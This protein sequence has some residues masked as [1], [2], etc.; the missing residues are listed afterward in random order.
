MHDCAYDIKYHHKLQGFIYNLLKATPYSVLHNKKGYKFISFSNIFPPNDMKKGDTKQLII[1][2]PDKV[3]INVI[4]EKLEQVKEKVCI[5]EMMFEIEGASMLEPKIERSC[6][7]I[8]G[9]PIIIRTSRKNYEEYGIKP[10]KDYDYV[11]WRKRYSFEAFIKQLEANLFK[12]YIQLIKS[13]KAAIGD[14]NIEIKEFNNITEFA[15]KINELLT[16]DPYKVV[17]EEK[18]ESK[19]KE[20]G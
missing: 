9:T 6:T 11:Y 18:D 7:L 17:F 3:L 15:Q 10:T 14:N 19:K 1:S 12:K 8:T 5:G 16:E 2:S 20:K 4:R 13:I